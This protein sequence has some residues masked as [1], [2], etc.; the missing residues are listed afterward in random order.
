MSHITEIKETPNPGLTYITRGTSLETIIRWEVR[1][2]RNTDTDPRVT[3]GS[4][5]RDG[6]PEVSHTA[7]I[8]NTTAAGPP[9]TLPGGT[10]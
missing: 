8:H 5:A 10:G 7:N 6:V 3:T 2:P 9:E 4:D 1:E